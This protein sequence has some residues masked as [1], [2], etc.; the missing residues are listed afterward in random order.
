MRKHPRPGL[1]GEKP[2]RSSVKH[3]FKNCSPSLPG[4][5]GK[6][7]RTPA[8]TGG[9]CGGFRFV[10]RDD[11]KRFH[12]EAPSRSVGNHPT[13]K[14][15]APERPRQLRRLRIGLQVRTKPPPARFTTNLCVRVG[16]RFRRNPNALPVISRSPV[17]GATMTPGIEGSPAQVKRT[18]LW[19]L[20]SEF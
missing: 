5:N 17:R 14:S 13:Y 19:P 4:R 9:G 12:A 15:P 6:S 3:D 7:A 20:D 2:L 1:S 11:G 10:A 16:S 18:Y 8:P